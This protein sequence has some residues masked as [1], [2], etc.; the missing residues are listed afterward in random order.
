MAKYAFIPSRAGNSKT[1]SNLKDFFELAGYDVKVL[2]DKSSIFE[3]YSGAL[4]ECKVKASDKV[5]MCHDDIEILSSPEAFKGVGTSMMCFTR[6]K[7][8]KRGL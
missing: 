5:V 3:A 2:V 6:T 7:R 8:L 1:L 4:R